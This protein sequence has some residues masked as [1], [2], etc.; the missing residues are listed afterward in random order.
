MLASIVICLFVTSIISFVWVS[1]IDKQMK[2]QKENPDYNPSEGWLDWDDNKAT[3]EG[4][5]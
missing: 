5:I 3:T 1:L 4:K 2:Y